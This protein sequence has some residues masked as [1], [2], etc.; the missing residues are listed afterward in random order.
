MSY[1]KHLQTLSLSLAM[2]LAIGSSLPVLGALHDSKNIPH[3]EGETDV[4]LISRRFR[5]RRRRIRAS[6]RRRI[7]ARRGSCFAKGKKVTA[8]LPPDESTTETTIDA[9]ST[10]KDTIWLTAKEYPT[11][12]FHLPENSANKAEFVLQ[13][14]DG[15]IAYSA[16][17]QLPG[18]ATE[19]SPRSAGVISLSLADTN[20]DL[21][22]LET[23]K[24]YIWTLYIMCNSN[25]LSG[26]PLINGWI[27]KIDPNSPLVPQLNQ[28]STINSNDDV[29]G[30]YVLADELNKVESQDKPLVYTDAGIWYDAV[31]SLAELHN[32]D[33]DNLEIKSDWEELLQSVENEE[34]AESN[35][36]GSAIIDQVF[37]GQ[38]PDL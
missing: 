19:D 30:T 9:N 22:P 35:I 10:P 16:T 18:Q 36:V 6:R 20:V 12:F 15:N 26:N 29:D 31:T 13:D 32:G 2:A 28:D 4:L 33:P 17:I 21:P 37:I 1:S 25:D 38:L 23:G 11:V 3:V 14:K 27:Q 5:F 34:I 7:G 8:L 24:S